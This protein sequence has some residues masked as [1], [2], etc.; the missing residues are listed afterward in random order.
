[1]SAALG[2]SDPQQGPVTGSRGPGPRPVRSGAVAP[3]PGAAAEEPRARCRTASRGL[4][5]RGLC[6]LLAPPPPNS[7]V[8]T[9]V[10][11]KQRHEQRGRLKRR[12]WKT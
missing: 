5:P 6:P 3:R 1:M 10:P 4:E 7:C 9:V 2:A 12:T 11:Q 8:L